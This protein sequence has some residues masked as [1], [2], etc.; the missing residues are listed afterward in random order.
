MT[1]NPCCFA[2]SNDGVVCSRELHAL[3][4]RAIREQIGDAS[5]DLVG[6]IFIE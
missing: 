2:L 6:K 5:N 1:E 4:M 3:Y